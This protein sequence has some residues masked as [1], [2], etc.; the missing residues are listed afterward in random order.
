MLA[1]FRGMAVAAASAAAVIAGELGAAQPATAQ[2]GP[3][4]AVEC[5]TAALADV[6]TD[7]PAAAVLELSAGCDYRLSAPL[8]DITKDLTLAGNRASISRDPAGGPGDCA[9]LAV[10]HVSD[11]RLAVTVDGVSFADGS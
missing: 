9:L 2:T 8:P 3:A 4:Q 6:I 10:R 7:A 5:S 1:A 11:R